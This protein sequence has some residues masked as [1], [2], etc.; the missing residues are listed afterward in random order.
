MFLAHEPVMWKVSGDHPPDERFARAVCR[1][2]W[3]VIGLEFDR[4]SGVLKVGE[5]QAPCAFGDGSHGGDAHIERSR[6]EGRQRRSHG[7]IVEKS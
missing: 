1:G 6:G 3:T 5:G 7:L 2:H 4:Q